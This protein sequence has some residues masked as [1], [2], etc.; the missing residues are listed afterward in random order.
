MASY[1]EM[2]DISDPQGSLNIVIHE[3]RQGRRP[4]SM[5]ESWAETPSNR[6]RAQGLLPSKTTAST[7]SNEPEDDAPTLSYA[8]Q[9]LL[10]ISFLFHITLIA[11]FETLFFFLY[12]SAM[13]DAGVRNTVSGFTSTLL[14]DCEQL[15]PDVARDLLNALNV[16]TVEARG[17]AALTHGEA[18]NAGLAARAWSYV[19]GLFACFAVATAA[20]CLRRLPIPWRRLCLEHCGLVAVL[21]VFE[22][23]FFMTIVHPYQPLS[24]PEV[25]AST[26]AELQLACSAGTGKAP[27]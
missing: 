9:H 8:S 3:F 2:K 23:L 18:F 24:G 22:A 14:R 25:A 10:L 13:E 20:G 15:P 21:G 1:E 11:V 5:S 7:P 12:V 17:V 26:V 4:L 19:G 16:T 6:E 27:I